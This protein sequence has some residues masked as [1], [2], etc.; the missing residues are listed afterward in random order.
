MPLT[1]RE[2]LTPAAIA[3]LNS[4]ELRARAIVEGH[5]SG[6]HRSPYR[7][8]SV[9][10]ADHREYSHG[11]ELR[12]LDWKVYARTDRFFIKEYDA[13][14]NLSVHLL[15]DASR[16]MDFATGAL[17][18]LDYA[19]SLCAGLAYLA[20]RQRDAAGL[21]TFDLQVR[22]RLPALTK[23]AHLQRLFDTLDGVT[24]GGE[25]NIAT[26]LEQIAAT[27]T[28]R[29]VIVLVSDLLDEPESVLRALGYFRHRGHDVLVLH[30]MDPGELRFDF[31]G[32]TLFQDIESGERMLS[33]GGEVRGEYL[34]AL[35]GFLVEL[36]DGCRHRSIDYALMDTSQPFDRALTAY[37]AHRQAA[38]G[39][40]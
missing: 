10:F 19:R 1:V 16:S 12:H 38:V 27:V 14:T 15:L 35:R 21:V 18:K 24:P 20:V 7:G 37:L 17:T 25:T 4:M 34:A 13:E 22:E 39:R 6:Q 23:R 5:Y 26:V 2:A 30:V 36:Q 3:K 32:P 29:G 40:R 9:E 31:R 8:A 28:R 11:D 33:D